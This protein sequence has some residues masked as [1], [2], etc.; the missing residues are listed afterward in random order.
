[1]LI[2][3]R[4]EFNKEIHVAFIDYKKV[5]DR[6][7]RSKLLE[8]LADDGTPNKIITMIYNLYGNNLITTKLNPKN[9]TGN[10]LTVESDVLYH[11]YLST[12]ILMLL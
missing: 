5:F 11:H 12:S 9:L 8:I 1:L 3:K 6:V 7:H 10:Q 2:E 4:K